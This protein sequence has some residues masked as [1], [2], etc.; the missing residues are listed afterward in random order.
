MISKSL[1]TRC[2]RFDNVT[3]LVVWRLLA[4]M[5]ACMEDPQMMTIKLAQAMD[6]LH[7]LWSPSQEIKSFLGNTGTPY[8][9]IYAELF[10]PA[11]LFYQWRFSGTGSELSQRSLSEVGESVYQYV[12][13]FCYWIW[14]VLQRMRKEFFSFSDGSTKQL[15]E[16]LRLTDSFL[17]HLYRGLWCLQGQIRFELRCIQRE[18]FRMYP[19]SN[20]WQRFH[21]RN[22]DNVG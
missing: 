13:K 5:V 17:L 15:G 10:F 7:F 16:A 9:W 21:M 8:G 18:T 12:C 22:S 19:L 11:S 2:T 4:A 3:R 6:K 1:H 20:R 14:F